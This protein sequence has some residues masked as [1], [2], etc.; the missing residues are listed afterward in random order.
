MIKVLLLADDYLE[1]SQ[2]ESLLKKLGFDVISLSSDRTLSN[3]MLSFIPDLFVCSVST[4]KVSNQKI[5]RKLR[6]FDRFRFKS[7]FLVSSRAEILPSDLMEMRVDALIEKPFIINDFL[8]I[9]SRFVSVDSDALIEKYEKIKNTIIDE[10][11]NLIFV[12]SHLEAEQNSVFIKKGLEDDKVKDSFS[13][14]QRAETYKKH[15]VGVPSPTVAHFSKSSVTAALESENSL[16]TEEAEHLDMEK[17]AFVK[18]LYSLG[19][20]AS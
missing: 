5:G 14:T 18:A 8:E 16:T 20:I 6:E 3:E 4:A 12:T 2:F 9:L 17:Q 13:D 1:R 10:H 11:D 7:I 19:K 15:L